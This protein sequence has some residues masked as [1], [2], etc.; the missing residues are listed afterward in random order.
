MWLILFRAFVVALLAHAGWFYSPFQ[1]NPWLGMGL[2]LVAAGGLIL[3]E[4]RMRAVSGPHLVGALVGGVTGLFAA[5]LVWGALA[6]LDVMGNDFVH[7]L[8][9]VFLAYVGIVI[10]GQKGEWVEPARL[11]APLRDSTPPH[12]HKLPGPSVISDGRIADICETG[13]LEGTLVVPQFVLRELQQV[14]DSSD[15]LIDNRGRRGRDIPQD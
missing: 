7:M 3:L 14:A 1:Q 10:G 12:A 2:G 11:I 8:L 4:Q 6:G 13:F 5:R 15:S 9:V